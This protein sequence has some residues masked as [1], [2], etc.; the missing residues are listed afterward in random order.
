MNQSLHEFLN[1]SQENYSAAKRLSDAVNNIA[2]CYP[3]EQ[4]YNAWI[5]VKLVDG[6]WD[7]TLYESRRDAVRHQSDEK[8]CAYLAM[9]EAPG[10]MDVR[11]AYA[12]LT[13]HRAA[14]D[15]GFRLPDPDHPTGGP[16][17]ITPLP[18]EDFGRQLRELIA[19]SGKGK[20]YYR[21]R[22]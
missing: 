13:Y 22:P 15:A 5:A 19:R 7:G 3:P 9:R 1:M 17:L 6:S 8:L 21:G 4:L 20:Q 11:A 14:Y 18:R 16:T 2:I 12:V 10:G